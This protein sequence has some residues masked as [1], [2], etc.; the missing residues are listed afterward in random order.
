MAKERLFAGVYSGAAADGVDAA[1][2]A[3]T[4]K[5]E[6]MH[7]RVV[8]HVSTAFSPALQKRILAASRGNST[9][10]DLAGLSHDLA[11]ATSRNVRQLLS[12]LRVAPSDVGALG[13]SGQVL[14]LAGPQKD[15][16]G[17]AVLGG[18]SALLARQTD[19]P[20]VGEFLHSDLAA[21]GVGQFRGWADWVLLH[22]KTLS[23]ATVHLGGIASVA[24]L[25]AGAGADE[26]VCFDA[27]PG[28]L[29]SDALA[30][31]FL[32]EP[33]DADGATAAKGKVNPEFLHELL[34]DE[35]FRRPL[36][37]S[38]S[39]DDW[40]ETCLARLNLLAAKHRSTGADLLATVTEL[41]AQAV[42]GGISQMTERPHEVIL[43]GGG[44]RN[45]HLASRI[46]TLLC[47]C[48]TVSCEKFGL[49]LLAKQAACYALLAAARMDNI[50]IFSRTA[51]DSS[52]PVLAGSVTLP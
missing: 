23:R 15:S 41:S 25:G 44:A 7:A 52:G 16:P 22:H 13:S 42:A 46:R 47:P 45:I 30:R 5:G 38:S 29:L 3:V 39:P 12:V 1:L 2:L 31:Q 28:T 18:N 40:G 36:P 20:V 51:A 37:R 43:S 6:K 21:G 48:S 17:S 10:S 8:G 24:F 32:N 14:F 11:A 27:G 33:C 19:L 9:I 50:P 4:G 34:A 49:G 26:V 35:F